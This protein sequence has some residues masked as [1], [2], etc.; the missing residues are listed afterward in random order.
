M[1]WRVEQ[2]FAPNAHAPERARHYVGAE[3]D[4]VL[5][6]PHRHELTDDARLTVSELVT[7]A[8]QAKPT[9]SIVVAL[10]LH[11][12]ALQVEVRDDAA[13]TPV[14]REQA[15]SAA[16]GRGL[17]IIDRIARAW[18]VESDTGRKTVWARFDVP[19]GLTEQLS[20]T[21]ATGS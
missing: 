20:C 5:S 11:H 7:N 16:G 6:S 14:L 3:L 19:S 4:A 1:C 2:D 10:E 12:G 18:G 13:G 8:I 17:L 9:S 15:A 21:V